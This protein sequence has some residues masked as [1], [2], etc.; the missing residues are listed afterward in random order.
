MTQI[1]EF[2]RTVKLDMLGSGD[3]SHEISA[4]ETER[5]AL[6]VRFGLL[7]LGR[8][9]ATMALAKTERGIKTTGALQADV[10]QACT[11]TGEA[12]PD[13]INEAIEL[14]FVPEPAEDGE[15]E[16]DEEE[17]DSMFHDGKVVDIGEAAAQT[18]GLA[19]NP[20]PRSKNA[21][22]KLREAG[23]KTEDE[24]KVASG[25]FAALAALKDKK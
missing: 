1:N 5:A 2:C 21:D 15:V 19:L 7:S 13:H 10:T 4:N 14:L 16:L 18:L 24:E 8:L 9:T 25:P 22:Q 3:V 12:V 11:A 17:C 23:V 20:Y 6:C